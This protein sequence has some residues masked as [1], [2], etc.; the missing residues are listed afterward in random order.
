MTAIKK[1]GEA[2]EGYEFA[3]KL[4]DQYDAASGETERLLLLAKHGVTP[5]ELKRWRAV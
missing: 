1:R 2:R 4:C 3:S 5:E